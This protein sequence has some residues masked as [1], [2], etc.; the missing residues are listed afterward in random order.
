MVKNCPDCGFWKACGPYSNN[1][2]LIDENIRQ[3]EYEAFEKYQL[4]Q[5]VKE[6]PRGELIEF[7][8]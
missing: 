7:K 3:R 2:D 4:S 8:K 1:Y 6:V 5:A